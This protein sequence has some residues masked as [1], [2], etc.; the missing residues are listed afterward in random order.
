[1]Y[2]FF[3]STFKIIIIINLFQVVQQSNNI[4]NLSLIEHQL[5]Q[6][7]KA[8]QTVEAPLGTFS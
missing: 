1:M 5:E 3:V 4:E 2:T 6:A 8:I 7:H